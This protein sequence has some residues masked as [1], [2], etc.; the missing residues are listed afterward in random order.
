MKNKGTNKDRINELKHKIYYA[1][2][3]RDNYKATHSI[4]YQTNIYYIDSLRQKLNDLTY[5][6]G[7]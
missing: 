6:G 7:S 4:L 5:P 3:A 1:E 2:I